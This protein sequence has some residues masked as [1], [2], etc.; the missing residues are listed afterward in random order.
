[1]YPVLP[2]HLI[3]TVISDLDNPNNYFE[4]VKIK[5][6]LEIVRWIGSVARFFKEIKLFYLVLFPK[7]ELVFLDNI[8]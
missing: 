7:A 4:K 6:I 2:E 3:P 5:S 1:M 8:L